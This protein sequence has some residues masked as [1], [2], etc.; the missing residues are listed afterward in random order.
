MQNSMGICHGRY[1]ENMIWAGFWG[2]YIPWETIDKIGDFDTNYEIGDAVDI[3]WSYRVYN[4]GLNI[5]P[6][7]YFNDHHHQTAHVN[8]NRLDLEDIR[9][10]NGEFFKR[11]YG[12]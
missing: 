7:R 12:L 4:A 3:D 9:K 8:E 6:I 5:I 10:R 11:K 2:I 1:I